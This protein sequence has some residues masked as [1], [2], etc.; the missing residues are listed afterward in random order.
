[1]PRTMY[2]ENIIEMLEILSKDARISYSELAR[3]LGISV[4]AVAKRVEA[5]TERGYI[6]FVGLVD[7]RKL[8]FPEKY[9]LVV[10]RSVEGL[11]ED[12]LTLAELELPNKK[13]VIINAR[14]T[15]DLLEYLKKH[16]ISP[17]SV[18]I[19]LEFKY[20]NNIPL[21]YADTDVPL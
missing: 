15:E 14:S 4:A 13:I 16:K 1:M 11:S 17:L 18:D 2:R 12:P 10:E 20:I 3:K 5:L 9:A 8:G 6:K 7:S 19:V 21:K